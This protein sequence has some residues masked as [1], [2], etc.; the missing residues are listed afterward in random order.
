MSVSVGVLREVAEFMHGVDT[1]IGDALEAAA[2]D[3]EYQLKAEEERR[4]LLILGDV[5][6]VRRAWDEVRQHDESWAGPFEDLPF[7]DRANYVR[8]AALMAGPRMWNRAQRVPDGVRFED[9]GGVGLSWIREGDNKYREG[10]IGELRTPWPET[11]V[12][13]YG[14]FIEETK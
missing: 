3:L 2:D 4:E 8:F 6:K 1:Y 9:Q 13:E 12:N 5:D 7:S 10:S 14:P 11:K